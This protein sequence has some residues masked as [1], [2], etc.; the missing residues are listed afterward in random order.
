MDE[1]LLVMVRQWIR[2][3][4]TIKGEPNMTAEM[5]RDYLNET[6]MPQIAATKTDVYD[7][8]LH[9][10]VTKTTSNKGVESYWVCVRTARSWLHK[11]G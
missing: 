5:F 11:L 3:N 7:P 10:P 2:V 1:G 6:I 4:S 8:F 9:A